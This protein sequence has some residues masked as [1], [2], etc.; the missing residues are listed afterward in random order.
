MKSACCYKGPSR[1][2]DFRLFRS[3]SNESSRSE[4]SLVIWLKGACILKLPGNFLHRL[5]EFQSLATIALDHK[6]SILLM[7]GCHSLD[8][9][10]RMCHVPHYRIF[11][12]WLGSHPA[13]EPLTELHCHRHCHRSH[14]R[15]IDQR[16]PMV[17]IDG[18]RWRTTVNHCQTTGQPPPNQRSTVVVHQS[19][20]QRFPRG[21]Q[22]A[23]A[24]H[25]VAAE[26]AEG[27]YP[28]AES[29]SR[30]LG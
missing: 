4:G 6:P 17:A 9:P 22:V 26:V 5:I 10:L 20:G 8:L 7:T 29:N 16:R 1:G 30:P 23:S 19:T 28:H 11:N 24:C 12:D 3:S 27:I 14:R 15:T 2:W 13:S 21:S 18:Q 25:H